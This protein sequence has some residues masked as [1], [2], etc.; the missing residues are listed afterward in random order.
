MAL[1]KNDLKQIE[2]IVGG[3]ETRLTAKIMSTGERLT[4]KIDST[5]AEIITTLSRE[6]TDLA[7]IN[8]A[9]I[10]RLDKITELEKRII[11]IETKLGLAKM[12]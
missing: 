10:N 1:E 5:K 7:E 11:R 4:K 9:V 8:H 12:S 3:V 6:V 2:K